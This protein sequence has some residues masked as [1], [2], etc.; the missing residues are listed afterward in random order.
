MHC[1]DSLK[2]LLDQLPKE[3]FWDDFDLYQLEGFSY[4]PRQVEAVIGSQAHFEARDDDIMLASPMKTG[5][6]WL[7]AL[8][9]SIMRP[10]NTANVLEGKL[11]DAS[12]AAIYEVLWRCSLERL[13]NLDVNKSGFNH[14]VGLPNSSFFRLGVVGDWKN[15]FTAEM[16]E[17]LDQITLENL[18]GFGLEFEI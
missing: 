18:E 4:D 11:K 16:R 12:R 17:R 14:L 1:S 15:N 13:E 3:S 9:L 7:K 2:P 6:T 5:T 10:E 8:C